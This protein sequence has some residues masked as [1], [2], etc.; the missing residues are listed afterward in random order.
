VAIARAVV[1]GTMPDVNRWA[2]IDVTASGQAAVAAGHDATAEAA[3]QILRDGGNAADA[4]V[5]AFYAAC[6]AEPMLASVGGGGFA[7]VESG[8]GRPRVLD[9]FARTPGR[10]L[11]IEDAS[12]I[13][14]TVDFTDTT[15]TFY[16]GMGTVA[17]PG[18]V[19]GTLKLHAELGRMPLRDVLAP[20]AALAVEGVVVNPLQENIFRAVTPILQHRDEC[21]ALF[22]CTDTSVPDAGSRL[23]NP[24]FADFLD[25]LSIEGADLF[26][27]GEI[28]R[29]IAAMAASGGGAINRDDLAR[30][31]PR[32]RDPLEFDFGEARVQINGA[33]SAGGMLLAFGLTL[34]DRTDPD[35]RR[36]E[37]EFAAVLLDT[38]RAT[39]LARV[40]ATDAGDTLPQI[41]ALLGDEVLN[42]WH[43]T[44]ARRALSVTGTTHINVV[45]GA[46]MAV[47]MTVS[48]GSGSGEVV[49]EAGFMLNNMLG[50]KDL[51]PAGIGQ[52]ESDA[53]VSSM[54]APGFMRYADG[55]LV[56]FGAGGSSRIRS[57]LLQVLA[58]IELAGDACEPAVEAP[59]F[60]CEN[61]VLSIE[62]GVSEAVDAALSPSYEN[63]QRFQDRNFFFGG[64]HVL[65]VGPA[66]IAGAGDPRRG[67][68]VR[69]F[70]V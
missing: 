15:Q 30:Y 43:D 23:G 4:S 44:L 34:L 35:W 59:R 48:N 68:V 54:M 19:A 47:A 6:V 8:N 33:P 37:P 11:P 20:A 25:S 40:H 53:P 3:E 70:P 69:V 39:E 41:D 62:G 12:I 61:E 2:Y 1:T 57:A 51:H 46:G 5:A 32:L 24:R 17:V 52:W 42:A 49:S 9:F 65:D 21:R 56:A 29:D 58:R 60:H 67:G 26:Y 18:G 55:R 36:T 64:V 38:M 27:R 50:E 7:A 31:S 28:A 66:G 13:P 16:I 10:Q 14:V 45:D 22:N 63:I